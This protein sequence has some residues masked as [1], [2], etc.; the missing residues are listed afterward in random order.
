MDLDRA[1]VE[2]RENPTSGSFVIAFAR[3]ST[4][5]WNWL[6]RRDVLP[7]AATIPSMVTLSL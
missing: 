5:S 4:R 7:Y 1:Q 3:V 6:A 2:R